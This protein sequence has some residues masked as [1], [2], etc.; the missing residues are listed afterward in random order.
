[1]SV[2]RGLD[3]LLYSLGDIHAMYAINDNLSMSSISDTQAR[4]EGA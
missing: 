1:M 4:E 2:L 3:I